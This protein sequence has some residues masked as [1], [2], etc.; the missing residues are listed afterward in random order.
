MNTEN[1]NSILYTIILLLE[2]MGKQHIKATVLSQIKQ[3]NE[4]DGEDA[5]SH[6]NCSKRAQESKKNE[7]GVVMFF[8]R[9]SARHK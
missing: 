8:L 2:N 7:Q 9:F 1:T 6:A 4:R 5:H 3:F